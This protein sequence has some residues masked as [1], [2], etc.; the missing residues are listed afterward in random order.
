MKVRFWSGRKTSTP[1]M[2]KG[3]LICDSEPIFPVIRSEVS[4]REKKLIMRAD[5]LLFYVAN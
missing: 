3:T 1:S 5:D 2:I 4:M